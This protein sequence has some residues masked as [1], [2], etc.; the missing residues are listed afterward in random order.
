MEPKDGCACEPRL[1]YRQK[2]VIACAPGVL[3]VFIECVT[4]FVQ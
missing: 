3:T 2:L 1:S 4:R